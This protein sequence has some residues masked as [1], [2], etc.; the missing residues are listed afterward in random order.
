MSESSEKYGNCPVNS[1]EEEGFDLFLHKRY[2]HAV[3]TGVAMIL[4]L[5][6]FAG[7]VEY[8]KRTY[9]PFTGFSRFTDTDIL[10]V[11][12]YAVALMLFVFIRIHQRALLSAGEADYT[13][14]DEKRRRERLVRSVFSRTVLIFTLCEAIALIG[15]VLFLLAGMATDFYVLLILALASFLIHLP[16][17]RRWEMYI[18]RRCGGVSAGRGE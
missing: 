8:I 12:L 2:F 14:H 6:I 4:S 11:I 1:G 3:L 9:M 15:L 13:V 10:R 5:F 16:R 18:E 7:V 17:Y